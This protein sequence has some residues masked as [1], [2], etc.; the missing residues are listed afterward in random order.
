MTGIIGPHRHLRKGYTMQ[1]I[2]IKRPGRWTAERWK[3]G[4]YIPA[5]PAGYYKIW[6]N[7]E[8]IDRAL[9]PAACR[10]RAREHAER[11]KK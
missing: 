6:H 9:T 8:V 1:R 5:F 2:A 10:R 11:N 7:G 3:G 4:H